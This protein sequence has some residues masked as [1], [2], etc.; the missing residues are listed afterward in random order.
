MCLVIDPNKNK[1]YYEK[2]L[3]KY[4][5]NYRKDK[6][7]KILKSFEKSIQRFSYNIKE[8][9][10]ELEG[11]WDFAI[12]YHAKY[13]LSI[14]HKYQK[15]DNLTY[16]TYLYIKKRCTCEFGDLEKYIDHML[17]SNK[18][19]TKNKIIINN[20]IAKE[21]IKLL[22][23]VYDDGKI[24]DTMRKCA[25]L[26]NEF[27]EL[28]KNKKMQE[29]F[30]FSYCYNLYELF[31]FL[32]IYCDVSF[33]Y[34]ILILFEPTV[35]QLSH[36]TATTMAVE[37]GSGS[38]TSFNPCI[39]IPKEKM[40]IYKDILYLKKYSHMYTSHN[41]KFNKKYITNIE[42]IFEKYNIDHKK[43]ISEIKNIFF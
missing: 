16:H 15:N 7:D 32:Y 35:N 38:R 41:Y 6:V 27:F 25:N 14:V 13:I 40:K 24:I 5:N 10:Y 43:I 26:Y 37:S 28:L 29:L 9:E 33:D 21:F 36:D 4:N 8:I 19:E 22:N 31:I 1:E 20:E 2:E 12:Q 30:D 17:K 11:L 39:T 23:L 18:I 42:H 3:F 34:E